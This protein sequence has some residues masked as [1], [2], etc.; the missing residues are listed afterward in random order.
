[1]VTCGREVWLC[2]EICGPAHCPIGLATEQE[3]DVLLFWGGNV[4]HGL[5]GASFHVERTASAVIADVTCH[6]YARRT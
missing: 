3:Y 1:M 4:L 5:Q 6:H 2:I